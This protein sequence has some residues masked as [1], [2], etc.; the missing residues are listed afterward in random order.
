MP[1][2]IITAP[3]NK[4]IDGLQSAVGFTYS[5]VAL[6]HNIHWNVVGKG[7]FQLHGALGEQY[8]ALFDDID[9]LA[10]RIRALDGFVQ[11][12]L[13]KFAAD[14]GIPELVAPF[15]CCDAIKM[16][17]GAHNKNISSLKVLV[18]VCAK[19]NDLETQNMILDMISAEQKR[20]WMLSSYLK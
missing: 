17:V 16:L 19:A 2:L 3:S 8:E 7:F 1:E 5:L 14:S 4:V 12:N 10:E 6:T 11:V 13:A 15:D 9:L 18:E 20:V